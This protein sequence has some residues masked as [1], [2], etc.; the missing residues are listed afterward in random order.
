M[1]EIV[2]VSGEQYIMILVVGATGL[3]GGMVAR[4]LL[5]ANQPV[6]ITQRDNPAYQSLIEAGAQPVRADLKDPESLARACE[7]VDVVI[8]TANSAQR[9]GED[10]AETVEIQ[11][12]KNLVEAA[13]AAGVQQFIFTSALG[14][15]ENSPIP[16]VRG[17][18]MTERLLRESG[19]P[20]TILVANIF[21]DVWWG[22][23]IGLPLQMG[24]PITF[25]GQGT[26]R[27]S[28]VAARDVA[29]F[30]VAAVNHP[31]AINQSLLIGGP[32]SLSYTDAV[33]IAERLLGTSLPIEYLPPGSAFPGVPPD[34]G[35][36][37]GALM[38]SSD[39][40]NTDFDM[41]ETAPRFGVT[42]TSPEAFLRRM[43]QIA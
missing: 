1:I 4:Q 9:G 15:D 17:K 26:G 41:S 3:M 24:K 14:S 35:M 16:F 36:V 18:G 28:F 10:T 33:R 19:M 38:A 12:N 31:D 40:Y 7:R 23:V 11:G 37:M 21:M 30:A 32:E 29:A 20:Y 13:K 43:L 42:L 2:L 5:A 22:A 6:R 39:G 25:V 27:H 34:A 8:T